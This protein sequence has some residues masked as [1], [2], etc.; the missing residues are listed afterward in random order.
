MSRKIFVMAAH[1]RRRAGMAFKAGQ[2]TPVTLPGDDDEAEALLNVLAADPVL[3][4]LPEFPEEED[5]EAA[6]PADKTPAKPKPTP[7]RK[8][9]AKQPEQ[10]TAGS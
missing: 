2:N 5:D 6:D 4:V 10:K 8:P 1:D 7:R 9:A 3:Q